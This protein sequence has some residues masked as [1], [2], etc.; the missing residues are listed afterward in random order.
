MK[1]LRILLA[2][3]G[4]LGLLWLGTAQALPNVDEVQAA[5]QRGD[6]AG[7]EKMMREVVAAKPDSARAHYV[8]AEL[9]AHRREF[10]EAAEHASRARA[11][12]PA[13]RF[14]DATR[15]NTFEQALQRQLAAA[16]D[17]G[18]P[19]ALEPPP[20]PPAAPAERV[21]RAGSLGGVP[22][23]LWVA[24]AILAVGIVARLMRRRTAAPAGPAF[25]GGGY[26][27]GAGM[28]Y[29]PGM[30]RGTGSASPGLM[31][32]GLAAAGGVAAGLLADRMLNGGR[33]ETSLPRDGTTGAGGS[34]LVPGSFGSDAGDFSPRDIDFGS[35]DGW[36][37]GGGDF[38]SDGGGGGGDDW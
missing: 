18:V 11:L 32:V 15:F 27:P 35:G 38:G 28:G 34:G 29:G 21:E 13:I 20:A 4:L 25:A 2:A 23:W 1:I 22:V 7:A 5:V 14:T 36:D 17:R 10:K 30:P 37:A 19:A 16:G 24:G 31:G 9:L 8:L 6:H 26:V 33:D 3:C 12:D